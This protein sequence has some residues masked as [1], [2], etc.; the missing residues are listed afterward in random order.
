MTKN[1]LD[2]GWIKKVRLALAASALRMR[3]FNPTPYSPN[4]KS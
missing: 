2:G 4:L 3:V 1:V